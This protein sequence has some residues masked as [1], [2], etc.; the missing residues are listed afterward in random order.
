MYSRTKHLVQITIVGRASPHPVLSYE[1]ECDT[2]TV[3]ADL[4]QA[5]G[6]GHL[7]RNG[8]GVVSRTLTGDY[9][10]LITGNTF[11]VHPISYLIPFRSI[12]DPL[13]YPHSA[14]QVGKSY[15]PRSTANQW[16]T[17][18]ICGLTSFG[19]PHLE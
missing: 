4:F 19:I 15:S 12:L 3:K 14:P 5:F 2:I 11:R 10:Y 17:V 9:D 8:M 7:Q 1:N 6:M 13:Q 16:L 18:L